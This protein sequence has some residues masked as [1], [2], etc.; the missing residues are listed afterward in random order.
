MLS[1]QP[2]FDAHF[3]VIDPRFPMKPNL[4]YLPAQFTVADYVHTAGQLLG[5]AGF[6]PGGGVVVSGSFQGTDQ[7]HLLSTLAELGPRYVGV[8]ML[9]PDVPDADLKRLDAAGVRGLRLNL[10]RRVH[11]GDLSDHLDL[12]RRARAL[13]GWH[14]ELYVRSV[15]LPPLRE[16]LPPAETVVFDHLGLTTAGLPTLLALVAEG[17]RV[18]ATGFSRGDLVVE[19][20]LLAVHKANPGS[21]LA[22]TDLPGTRAPRAVTAADL[23]LLRRLFSAEDVARITY[24]NAVELYRPSADWK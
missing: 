12:A 20:A 6:Q 4:H 13:V 5:V 3:H 16:L 22:G 9:P 1:D 21:L 7:K 10:V 17:A 14:V 19:S 11:T 24:G 15:D 23:E 18:K 8:T 2:F